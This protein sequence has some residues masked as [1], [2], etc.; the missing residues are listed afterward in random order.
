MPRI[1]DWLGS[2]LAELRRRNVLQVGAG[3]AVAAWVA[4]QV[5][6]VVLR[7]ALFLPPWVLT[8]VVVVGILGFPVALFLAWRYDLTTEGL[9]RA[10]PWD[11]ED[12]PDEPARHRV[13][14]ALT[15]VALIA[16]VG[17]GWTALRAWTAARDGAPE[18]RTAAE[19]AAEAI[20]DPTRIAVLPFDDH[21]PGG[22]LAGVASGLTGDLIQE[23]DRVKGLELVSYTGVQPFRDPEVTL[24]S[25]ARILRAGTLIEGSVER[26]GERLALSVNLVDGATDTRLGSVRI[27]RSRD[28]LLALRSALVEE[29][30][31]EL[32]RRLGSELELQE[33]RAGTADDR[34]W[35]LFHRAR[36][37]RFFADTLAHRGDTASARRLFDQADSLLAT[38]DE[39]ADSW[40]APTVERARIALARAELG[41]RSIADFD[42]RWLARGDSL[43]GVVLAKQPRNAEALGVRGVIRFRASLVPGLDAPWASPESAEAALRRA[44]DIDPANS[45]AWAELSRLLSRDGRTGEAMMAARRSREADPFLGNDVQYLFS[46]A[47]LELQLQN[48]EKAEELI[49]RGRRLFPREPAYDV[50]HLTLLGGPRGP[51]PHPDSAWA[52]LR[53]IE[54]I[55]GIRWAPGRLL[56]AASLVRTGRAD[57]ARALLRRAKESASDHPYTYYNAANVH[58]QLGEPDSAVAM[59]AS[60]LDTLPGD[61]ESV[62]NDWWFDSIRDRPDFQALVETPGAASPGPGDPDISRGE[63]P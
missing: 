37:N 39:L 30:A 46:S 5:A 50:L 38:A 9:R 51:E 54:D 1:S 24:D 63:R 2:V 4:F 20:L 10:E 45:R 62:A 22:S 25:V 23:L 8:L 27:E 56:V 14:V 41:L 13:A 59:L 42:T 52:L 16:T 18:G 40:S 61:R 47:W 55:Y 43:A 31:R 58:L 44:V 3:Y 12:A 7:D 28:S 49:R 60:Y 36:E 11:A 53:R 15:F 32:R 48:F 6:A 35:E 26:A 33:L 29:V 17:A 57:S 19:A 21:S 34:A